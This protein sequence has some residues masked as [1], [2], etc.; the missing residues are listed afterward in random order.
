MLILNFRRG[1]LSVEDIQPSFLFARFENAPAEVEVEIAQQA[2][3]NPMF[4][5]EGVS[6]FSIFKCL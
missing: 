3:H 4:S 1:T 2:F 6:N 5:L